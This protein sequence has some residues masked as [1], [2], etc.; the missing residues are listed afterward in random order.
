MKDPE[1]DILIKD[2]ETASMTDAG[3]EG[4]VHAL[5]IVL[6]AKATQ[7]VTPHQIGTTDGALHVADNAYPNWAVHIH[8]RANDHD[9]HWHCSLRENDSFDND[10]VIGAGRAPVLAQA[11]LAAVLRLSMMLKKDGASG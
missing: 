8:G 11:I 9:G 2:L 7:G 1:I 3:L 4:V 6:P 10:A 5:T